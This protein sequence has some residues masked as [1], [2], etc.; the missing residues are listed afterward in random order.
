MPEHVPPPRFDGVERAR[1]LLQAS[2]A[3]IKEHASYRPAYR[4]S[5]DK[6][7]LPTPEA[8]GGEDRFCTMALRELAH[9]SGHESRL[10]RDMSHPFGSEGRVREEL[11]AELAS[12]LLAD[13]LGLPPPPS[14]DARAHAFADL[15]ARDP[16]ELFRAAADAERIHTFLMQYDKPLAQS[17]Q[18]ATAEVI[19]L[20]A[21]ENNRIDAA[22]QAV[23]STPTAKPAPAAKAA[24]AFEPYTPPAKDVRAEF[25]D[26]L[27][28]MGCIVSGDHPIMDG[29]PH[30]IQVAGDKKS[31]KAGFYVGHEDGEVPAGYISNNRS[32]QSMRWKAK[33]YSL[34]PQDRARLEAEAKANQ[35]RR[36]AEQAAKHSATSQRVTNQAGS[37]RQIPQS[38]PTPYLQSKGVKPQRGALTDASGQTTFLPAQDKTGRIWTMQYIGPEGTKRFAKDSRKN[39]CFHVL[40]GMDEL[41]RA[42]VIVVGEGYATM[43]TIKE[44]VGHAVVAAFD[45]G[46]LEPVARALREM[47]LTKPMLLVG[48]DDRTVVMTQGFNPGREKAEAAAKAVG[49]KAVFPIFA[50]DEITYPPNL[51]PVTPAA[52]RAHVAAAE[53]L[54]KVK[55]GTHADNRDLCEA[56]L[57]QPAQL[58]ALDRMKQFT[59]FNDLA[60]KSRLGTEAVR[61]QIAPQISQ[62]VALHD[63]KQEQAVEQA[64]QRTQEQS[65]TA[66]HGMQQRQ[67]PGIRV[68]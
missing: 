12:V 31:E 25:A 52:F 30:R 28:E 65:R 64:Q 48:D 57:L 56:D 13:T 29:K 34:N 46:N 20:H 22:L 55:P 27:R 7:Q 44:T 41:K 67:R 16:L 37:L 9:W 35:Q 60:Q 18:Q 47:F 50:P 49:A 53:W 1:G 6:I 23:A 43:A 14:H 4:A 62:L 8:V 45:S 68:R 40:G 58:D 5:A 66:G 10:D 26:A 2:G 3:S 11:R 51:K 39:G 17:Q 54:A 36:E 61:R 63:L 32:G 42:P 33:G 24:R 21:A 38:Q 59:D 15:L 19:A